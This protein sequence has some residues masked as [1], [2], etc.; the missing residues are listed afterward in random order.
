MRALLILAMM[1]WGLVWPLSKMLLEFGSPA[2]IASARYVLVSACFIPIMLIGKISF[3]IPK[4]ARTPL[5]LTGVLN[6]LYSYLMYVGMP[7]GDSGHAG[8]I[9]EVLSPI[10]AALLWSAYTRQS[11]SANARFGLA[12]G[13][14]SCAFLIDFFSNMRAIFSAFYMIYMLAALDWALLMLTSR[15]ATHSLNAIA[16]NFYSSLM[17]CALLAPALFLPDTNAL[18]TQSTKSSMM[19]LA[20]LVDKPLEFYALLALAAVFCT[21]F[22]TTIFYRALF[23]L[24]VV[25]GGIYALLV[26]IFSLGFAYMLLGE[27]PSLS[28]II[29]GILAIISIYLI[30][31]LKR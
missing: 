24:G 3:S 27:I 1:G 10:I 4:P 12:L 6:A 21:V 16:L 23:V 30:N 11:L 13:V 14:L 22:A 29:G 2:Q 7:Y 5:L 28:T 31:Y 26:P 9:T 25:E 17:T 15:K 18:D 20:A 19:F 8:V